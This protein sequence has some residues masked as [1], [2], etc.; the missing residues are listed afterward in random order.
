MFHFFLK[1]FSFLFLLYN[2]NMVLIIIN[3]LVLY[4]ILR[5]F[6]IYEKY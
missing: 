1:L 4:S 6:I 2:K 5:L 3:E